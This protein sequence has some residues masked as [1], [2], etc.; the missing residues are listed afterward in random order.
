M[1]S[2]RIRLATAISA[3]AVLQLASSATAEVQVCKQPSWNTPYRVACSQD[4]PLPALRFLADLAIDHSFKATW[5]ALSIRPEELVALATARSMN[6]DESLTAYLRRLRPIT[7]ERLDQSSG[8]FQ[9]KIGERDRQYSSVFESSPESVE[10]QIDLPERLSG[11]Y[12]R[13]P[14][15][16]QLAFWADHRIKFRAGSV[17]GEIECIEISPEGIRAVTVGE[18]EPDLMLRFDCQ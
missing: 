8:V 9:S 12:W 5:H 2:E 7:F 3:L 11:G 13:T 4:G 14:S 10:I 16:L 6:E 1:R 18:N 15:V 17:A